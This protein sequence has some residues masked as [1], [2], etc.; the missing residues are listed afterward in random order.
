[1]EKNTSS[2]SPAETPWRSFLRAFPASQSNSVTFDK[3]IKIVYYRNIHG[4][5][6]G[7]GDGRAGNSWRA[8]RRKMAGKSSLQLVTD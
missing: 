4:V 3:S 5:A 8:A 1:V 6:N 2:A 7:R